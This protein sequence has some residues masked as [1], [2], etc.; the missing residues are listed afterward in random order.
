MDGTNEREEG[1]TRAKVDGARHSDQKT[2]GIFILK[3][4]F[5][6]AGRALPTSS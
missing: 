4:S 2:D 5:I 3:A 1:M 6:E